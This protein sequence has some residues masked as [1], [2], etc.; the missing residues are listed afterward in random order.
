MLATRTPATSPEQ[1]VALV[2]D[3]SADSLAAD[4][5]GA[6]RHAGKSVE[7]SRPQNNRRHRVSASRASNRYR[8]PVLTGG[9]SVW[10][11][12]EHRSRCRR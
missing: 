12:A 2:A 11:G 10:F 1:A 6:F 5:S 3:L 7:R 8:V 4:R 9:R